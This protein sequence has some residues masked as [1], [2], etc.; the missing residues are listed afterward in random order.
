MARS[1][2]RVAAQAAFV[3]RRLLAEGWV[4]GALAADVRRA[5]EAALA[6]DRDRERALDQEVEALL[7]ANAQS[8]R[9][10]GADYAEMFR[11]AKKLLAQ[12]KG[13]PL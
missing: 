2:M 4:T 13:I 1:D 7:R 3:A 8:I 11:K 12:K 6:A 9:S 10:S 5:V